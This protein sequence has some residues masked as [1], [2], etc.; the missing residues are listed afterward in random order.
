MGTVKN[1]N[2]AVLVY[3]EYVKKYKY[4]GP[5]LFNQFVELHND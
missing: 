4:Y 2:V 1:R 3:S 5:E